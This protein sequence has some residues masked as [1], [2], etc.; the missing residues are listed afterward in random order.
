MQMQST[1]TRTTRSTRTTR[2]SRTTRRIRPTAVLGA[3]LS[4]AALAAS[5]AAAA[6]ASAA[7]DGGYHHAMANFAFPS[8]SGY[9]GGYVDC[10]AGR[11]P[12]AS[13]ALSH[14]PMGILMSNTLTTAGTGAYATASGSGGRAFTVQADCVPAS[15]L[16]GS[17]LATRVVRD[18]RNVWRDFRET[19]TCPS[20]TVAYGGG[21][22]VTSPEGIYDHRGLYISGS[23]P[24]VQGWTYAGTGSIGGNALVVEAHCLPRT[25]LGRIV[26]VDGAATATDGAGRLP[27]SASARC[28]VGT[29]PFSGGAW[30]R[31][32]GSSV[33]G[34]VGYFTASAMG[35]DGRSWFAAGTTFA[36]RA[37]LITRVLCTDRLGR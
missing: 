11:L 7:V 16:G 37:Q 23:V 10:P 36:P 5:V 15:V 13:G 2:P 34:L 35:A 24:G 21:G 26:V 22:T 1:T 32:E 9:A 19:V 20:G 29:F 14:D 12:I 17:T 3:A 31:A 33:P 25:R 27:I 6:P 8:T 18:R 28:P 4:A 30:F